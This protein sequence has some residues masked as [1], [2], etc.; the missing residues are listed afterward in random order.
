MLKFVLLKVLRR[1]S[2]LDFY[3]E[4]V[5]HFAF[6]RVII[7]KNPYVRCD[8]WKI[9]NEDSYYNLLSVCIVIINFASESTALIFN[10]L[11]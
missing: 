2:V 5:Q 6:S 3:D 11:F 10:D 7:F 8:H 4:N 9:V 1:R